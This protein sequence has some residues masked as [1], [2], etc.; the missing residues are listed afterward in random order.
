MIEYSA[1]TEIRID[2]SD[3]DVLG[4]VNHLAIMRYIQTARVLYF[5]L[6]GMSARVKGLHVGP[7]MASVSAQFKKQILYPGT[8]RVLSTINELKTTSFHMKH[9]IIDDEDDIAAEGHDVLVMFD[10]LT[11]DKHGISDDLRGKIEAIE[12]NRKIFTKRV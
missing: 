3:L 7:I 4:H 8:V 6:L 12:A 11:N 1:A 9:Y 2:W 5:E 10:F